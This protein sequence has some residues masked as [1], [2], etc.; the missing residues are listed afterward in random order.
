MNREKKFLSTVRSALGFTEKTERRFEDLLQQNDTARQEE[1]IARVERRSMPERRDLLEILIETGKPLNLK[2]IP[3]KSAS[4]GAAALANLV[5]IKNPEWGGAKSI[6]AWPHPLIEQLDLPEVLS[7]QNVPVYF[8]ATGNQAEPEEDIE[9]IGLIRDQITESFIGVTSADY[10]L[11]ETATLVLR[12]RPG[13]A[14]AAS[15][16][17]SIHVAVITID[18][19]IA[20]LQEL[21]A[22]LNQQIT[23][24]LDDL[25][26]CMTFISGPSKTADIE[27]TMVHGAHGPRELHVIVIDT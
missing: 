26:N 20:D 23:D 18:Q 9:K 22:I 7:D 25:T 15:L 16:V 10:C 2:I 6:A 4:A 19:I 1:I 5:A 17:P 8:T 24:G 13:Q 12:T 27:L 11:A 14:R 3:V 21:Y